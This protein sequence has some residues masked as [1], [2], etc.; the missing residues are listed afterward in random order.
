MENKKIKDYVIG[1]VT[2]ILVIGL[3]L[4]LLFCIPSS[5]PVPKIPPKAIFYQIEVEK[6]K[7]YKVVK[8]VKYIPTEVKLDTIPL[9]E[10]CTLLNYD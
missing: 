8:R 7:E 5:P 10:K 6:T 1:I 4:S 3:L 2:V 9:N